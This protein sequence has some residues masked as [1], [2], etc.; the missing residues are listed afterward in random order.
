MTSHL[1]KPNCSLHGKKH[2]WSILNS[3][4]RFW[5]TKPNAKTSRHNLVT[6]YIRW[7]NRLESDVY[8][9]MIKT[10]KQ[11]TLLY[12]KSRHNVKALRLW[13][14]HRCAKQWRYRASPN[15][16]IAG[17]TCSVQCT[18][19]KAFAHQS[20]VDYDAATLATSGGRWAWCTISTYYP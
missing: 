17:Q 14:R 5:I 8:V 18:T 15:D 13:W 7:D 3:N 20:T 2:L 9:E 16:V 4:I 12:T 11:V 19:Q 1:N 10:S 6:S